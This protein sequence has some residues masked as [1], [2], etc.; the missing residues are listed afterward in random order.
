MSQTCRD[1]LCNGKCVAQQQ[2]PDGSGPDTQH[3]DGFEAPPWFA[4][5]RKRLDSM[6]TGKNTFR[7]PRTCE[8]C[9]EEETVWNPP[10]VCNKCRETLHT[11]WAQHQTKTHE[12]KKYPVNFAVYMPNNCLGPGH[13][14]VSTIRDA[15]F[16]LFP[17]GSTYP[18]DGFERGSLIG[19]ATKRQ[20]TDDWRIMTPN[21]ALH[22]GKILTALHEV[23][24]TVYREGFEQ[25]RN[26]LAGIANGT[27]STD[28]VN[29]W[30]Q[31][32]GQKAP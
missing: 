21:Q 7:K 5:P 30:C 11:A 9:G 24:D 27:L 29:K 14:H 31:R 3:C 28:D 23:A 26:L 12:A 13:E 1:C 4:Q 22:L 15:L 32:Y 10:L 17:R 19:S 16:S 8:A 18:D 6:Y 25:G 2:H 20:D